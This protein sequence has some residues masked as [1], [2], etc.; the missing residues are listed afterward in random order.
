MGLVL[1]A[2]HHPP[3]HLHSLVYLADSGGLHELLQ[4]A[5]LVAGLPPDGE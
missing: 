1:V 3:V 5:K 4:P 2:R